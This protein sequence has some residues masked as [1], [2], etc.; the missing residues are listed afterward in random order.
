[1]FYRSNGRIHGSS[2]KAQIPHGV[3]SDAYH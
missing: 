3:S 2:L 1:M